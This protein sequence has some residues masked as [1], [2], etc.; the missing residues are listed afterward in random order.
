MRAGW[1][2]RR[3]AT[4][5][6][7]NDD[8]RA[9][10]EA[11]EA[12][13]LVIT[14]AMQSGGRGRQGR[15]WESPQGNLYASVLLKPA[16]MPR[17]APFYGFAV[18]VSIAAA[19]QSCLPKADIALKWPN[20]VLVSG[21]KISGILLEVCADALIIGFGVNVAAAPQQTPYPATSLMAQGGHETPENLLNAVLAGLADWDEDLRAN[22]FGRLRQEWLRRARKGDMEVRLPGETL[23]G[24]FA[25]LD[26][27][28]RLRLLLADGTERAISTG[29]VFFAGV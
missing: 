21:A 1:R 22:G 7:T 19:L 27:E 14:A 3:L 6:S 13:G 25:D 20:D 8:V 17:V 15:V 18:A 29:D 5:A 11:G 2:I 28:G 24:T 26:A 4:T 23:R 10:A 9:A 16:G 12:E